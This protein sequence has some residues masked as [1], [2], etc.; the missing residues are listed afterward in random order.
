MHGASMREGGCVQAMSLLS[1]YLLDIIAFT[2]C[3][4]LTHY[5]VR[6]ASLHA[7]MVAALHKLW[8]ASI[9]GSHQSG[10]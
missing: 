2:A 9:L 3:L 4:I 7:V 8:V 1:G 6:T 10:D 5:G